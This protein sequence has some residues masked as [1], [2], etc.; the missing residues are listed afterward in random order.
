M[1]EAR[2]KTYTRMNTVHAGVMIK[3][4]VYTNQEKEKTRKDDNI[5][6]RISRQRACHVLGQ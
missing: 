4:D 5:T 1:K 6:A 3:I 2:E